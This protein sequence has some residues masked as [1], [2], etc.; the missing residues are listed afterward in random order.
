MRKMGITLMSRQLGG[1]WNFVTV[2][3]EVRERRWEMF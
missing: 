2:T 3:F 1:A